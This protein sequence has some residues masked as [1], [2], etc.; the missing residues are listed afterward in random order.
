[1]M[2]FMGSGDF[3][4]FWEGG[5]VGREY[6]RGTQASPCTPSPDEL[7]REDKGLIGQG[8]I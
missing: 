5:C 6:G 2:F 1:M 8:A 3:N 7:D 4:F